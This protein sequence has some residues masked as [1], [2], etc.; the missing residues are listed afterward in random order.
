MV[1]L[2]Q[3]AEEEAT[4]DEQACHDAGDSDSEAEDD[5]ASAT[6]GSSA[7]PGV[8]GSL[9][10]DYLSAKLSAKLS[11]KLSVK[12]GPSGSMSTRFS[13]KE[14]RSHRQSVA[15][16]IGQTMSTMDNQLDEAI[17]KVRLSQAQGSERMSRRSN[18]ADSV[19]AARVAREREAMHAS[20]IT[21]GPEFETLAE[22]DEEWEAAEDD[23]GAEEDREDEPPSSEVTPT[24]VMTQE[25][26]APPAAEDGK[27]DVSDAAAPPAAADTVAVQQTPP[28]LPE[29]PPPNPPESPPS[30]QSEPPPPKPS[31]PAAKKAA[32]AVVPAS[33]G[34]TKARSPDFK[35]AA[36]LGSSARDLASMWDKQAK[37]EAAKDALNPFSTNFDRSKSTG[38]MLK[39]GDAGYGQAP[40]G[41]LTEA[42]A[43]AAQ[44]WVDKEIDSLIE[45]IEKNGQVTAASGGKHAITFGELFDIYADIS[46]SLVG[47]LKRAKKRGRL[48]FDADMLFQG[49]H[50]DVWIRVL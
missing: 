30:K 44:A 21:D 1:Q 26:A 39:K 24:P 32:F 42:R 27:V 37:D 12:E 48:A 22:E 3:K 18:A 17:K 49:V 20:K 4:A 43:K 7:A 8:V 28:K 46:D 5:T 14:G 11:S 16:M 6:P 41:S 35:N 19:I 40:A 10:S 25:V 2:L 38:A 23:E 36:K 33:D 45:V 50:D 47:I 15:V 34:S 31:S 13:A 29:P 9:A